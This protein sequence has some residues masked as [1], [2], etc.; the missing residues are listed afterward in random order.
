MTQNRQRDNKLK[1]FPKGGGVVVES[2][3]QTQPTFGI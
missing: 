1:P 3:Q 2:K